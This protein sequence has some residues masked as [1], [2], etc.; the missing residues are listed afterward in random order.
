MDRR[1]KVEVFDMGREEI[2]KMV[3][4]LLRDGEKKVMDCNCIGLMRD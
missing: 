1:C 4:R 3:D 2:E